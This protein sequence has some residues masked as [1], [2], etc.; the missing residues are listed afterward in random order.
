MFLYKWITKNKKDFKVKSK[1]K[2]LREY[3]ENTPEL[4]DIYKFTGI[5]G[6]FS[7]ELYGVNKNGVYTLSLRYA[8]QQK[9]IGLLKSIITFI[10]KFPEIKPD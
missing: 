6:E 2:E 10:T 7:P 1:D 5:D 9:R 8:T 4:I 3:L